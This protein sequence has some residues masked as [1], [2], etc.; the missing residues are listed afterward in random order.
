MR[1]AAIDEPLIAASLGG[2]WRLGG[3]P[4]FALGAAANFARSA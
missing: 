3:S 2:F 1:G 4:D